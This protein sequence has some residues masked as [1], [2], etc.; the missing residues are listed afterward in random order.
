M[1]R[2]V[3]A[4]V[5]G[6]PESLSAATWAAKEAL[7]RNAPLHIV[8]AWE[9]APHPTVAVPIETGQRDWAHQILREAVDHVRALHPDLSIVDQQVSLPPVRALHDASEQSAL[10]V[11]G[12]RGI[13]GFAGYLVGSVALHVIARAE[14]PVALVRAG[15]Q[16]TKGEGSAASASP[17]EVVV[18][19]D[20]DRPCDEVVAFAFEEARLRGADLHLIHAYSAP[21]LHAVGTGQRSGRELQAEREKTLVAAAR[22]LHDRYPD[23]TVTATASQG[24]P[25]PRLLRAAKEAEL[26]VLGRRR[27]DS[28]FGHTGPVTHAAMHHAPCPV[29]VVPYD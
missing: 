24:R 10:L 5:D 6:S 20:F 8:H 9:W 3:T 22:Q 15:H 7:L 4:G 1:L 13:S 27:R 28:R 21:S 17:R 14:C 25:A 26:L 19:I 12:T 18:G 11:L 2:P 29:A 23:L 16:D